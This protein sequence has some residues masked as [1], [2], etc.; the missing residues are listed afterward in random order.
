MALT[1]IKFNKGN[2]KSVKIVVKCSK[3]EKKLISFRFG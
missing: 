2:K 3:I 1:K